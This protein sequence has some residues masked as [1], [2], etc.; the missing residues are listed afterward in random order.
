M[1]FFWFCCCRQGLDERVH[2]EEKG[3]DVDGDE[4]EGLGEVVAKD[5]AG[6]G[7]K[8]KEKF[9]TCILRKIIFNGVIFF[10]KLQTT[11]L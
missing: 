6:S 9:V 1:L 8:R 7:T 10:H 5:R 11:R 3:Q 4:D 2:Q